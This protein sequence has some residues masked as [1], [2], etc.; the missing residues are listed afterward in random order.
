MTT[1]F[2]GMVDEVRPVTRKNKETGVVSMN[3]MLTATFETRDKEGYLIKS[4]QE[5]QMEMADMTQLT[6]AKGK[7]IVIP[8]MT[9]NTKNGTYTFPND[10][11]GFQVYDKN[12]FQTKAS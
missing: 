9:L 12:P 3:L 11:M 8:Y 6:Q 4:V 7:Y 2:V 5:I 1:F 10:S